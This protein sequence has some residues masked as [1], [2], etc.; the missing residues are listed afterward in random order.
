MKIKLNQP[1]D[2]TFALRSYLYFNIFCKPCKVQHFQMNKHLTKIR[3]N[4]D[5][6]CCVYSI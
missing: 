4:H 2:I 3:K 5:V 6:A 1:A